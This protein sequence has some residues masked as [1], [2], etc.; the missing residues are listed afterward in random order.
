MSRC[1]TLFSTSL[2][3][4]LLAGC[5]GAPRMDAPVNA[6]WQARHALLEALTLWEFTGRI[7]VRDDK[8]SHSSRIRWQQQ[9]DRLVSCPVE[10]VSDVWFAGQGQ[11]GGRDLDA[12]V[13]AILTQLLTESHRC[14][15]ICRSGRA[16]SAQFAAQGCLGVGC[17]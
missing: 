2:L 5:A 16:A 4:L 13:E 10:K 7:G 9:G 8:E 11:I 14:S 1:R 12:I 17:R 15:F 3:C 6:D